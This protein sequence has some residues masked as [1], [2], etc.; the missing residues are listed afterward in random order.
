[1]GLQLLFRGEH[2]AAKPGTAPANAWV[3][4]LRVLHVANTH[5]SPALTAEPCP[6]DST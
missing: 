6:L 2:Q 5:S 1:M 3:G 4:H